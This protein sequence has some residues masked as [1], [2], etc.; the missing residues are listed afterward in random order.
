M[1]SIASPAT[2]S[3]SGGTS[4]RIKRFA[5][6]QASEDAD[7]WNH[8]DSRRR[9]R[10]RTGV[11]RSGRR[12]AQGREHARFGRHLILRSNVRS[13]R[14]RLDACSVQVAAGFPAR[15]DYGLLLRLLALRIHLM[16]RIDDKFRLVK[17]NVFR[18][19][20]RDQL[21]SCFAFEE[22]ASHFA[23]DCATLS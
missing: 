12:R 14:H 19:L 3:G 22:A 18:A 16:N 4:R 7:D 2:C 13:R 17:W 10:D 6:A 8:L 9:R 20:V 23:C 11:R 15:R 1:P 21:T 5:Q